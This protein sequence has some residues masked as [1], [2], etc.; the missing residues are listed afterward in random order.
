MLEYLCLWYFE[1][2]SNPG[3]EWTTG[4]PMLDALR[5]VSSL[6]LCLTFPVALLTTVRSCHGVKKKRSVLASDHSRLFRAEFQFVNVHVCSFPNVFVLLCLTEHRDSTFTLCTGI[7]H[8][9]GILRFLYRIQYEIGGWLSKLT[10]L[11]RNKRQ[12]TRVIIFHFFIFNYDKIN[13]LLIITG[14]KTA[15]K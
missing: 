12:I 11:G 9:A 2:N 4:K 1:Q 15:N 7:F 5:S 10:S 14:T 6:I 3:T 13:S 8:Y